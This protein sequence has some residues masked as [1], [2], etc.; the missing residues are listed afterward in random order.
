MLQ[1]CGRNGQ[2]EG[3]HRIRH[4]IVCEN[5]LFIGTEL[6]SCSLPALEGVL[7]GAVGV[8]EGIE[9]F[10]CLILAEHGVFT[11]DPTLVATAFYKVAVNTAIR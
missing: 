10:P 3:V 5:G 7:D 9:S 2:V 1:A 11:K 4:G 6:A 8:V